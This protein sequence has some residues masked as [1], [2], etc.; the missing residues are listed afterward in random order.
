MVMIERMRSP[1]QAAKMG[2]LQS[3]TE[4]SLRDRVRSLVILERPRVELL[5]LCVEKSQL[6]WF[7]H[8]IRLPQGRLPRE[9][10]LARPARRGPQIRQR[11]RW[12]DC[13]STLAWECLRVPHS[14]LDLDVAKYGWT[15]YMS[16]ESS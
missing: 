3:V 14:A 12:R 11:T 16:R 2:F 1:G 6:R 9:M 13:I 4:V 15:V 7:G 5:L 8:L 10:F